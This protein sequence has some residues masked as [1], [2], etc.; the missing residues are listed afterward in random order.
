MDLRPQTRYAKVGDAY[1]AYQVFGQSGPDL[2]FNLGWYSHVD[3]QWDYPPLAR[4]LRRLGS[5][6]RVICF[7]RRGHGMSDPADLDNITLEEWI[8]DVTAVMDSAGSERA[9]ILGGQEAG[10]MGLVFAATHPDRTAALV[11]LATYPTLR[12]H[13]DYPWGMPPRFVDAASI[14][15]E[16][17]AVDQH[18]PSFEL[19]LGAF[20]P[21]VTADSEE[22]VQFRRYVTHSAGP[23]TILRLWRNSVEVDV[24]HVLPLV[25]VPTLIVHRSDDG[26]CRVEHGRYLAEHIVGAKYVELEGAAQLVYMGDAEAILDEVQE[27]VTG[28]R[29][30]H[31]PDRVLATVLFTDIVSSTER[32]V[33]AGDRRWRETLDRHNAIVRRELERHRGREVSSAGDGFVATFDGPARAVRCA[34]TIAAEVTLLGLDVR[35][36]L[37]TG[38]VE[39]VGN[40]VAGIAVHIGRRVSDLAEPGEVLVSRTVVDLVAG[41]GIEFADRGAH[42]LK[43]VPGEFQLYA[44][45]R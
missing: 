39:L 31:E 12:R 16:R 35:A 8:D 26:W 38:E 17:I 7:D 13:D 19:L 24:R 40:D 21:G 43:G 44:V 5:F 14:A 3:D 36:G 28:V 4:F 23:A 15:I 6:S 25:R 11:L 37:H 32:A 29:P 9:V 45:T 33:A 34:C 42:A 10:P 1:V 30:V 41:S 2:V 27:F 20:A 22:A 18:V